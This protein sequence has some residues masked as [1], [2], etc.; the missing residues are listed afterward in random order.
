MNRGAATAAVGTAGFAFRAHYT[1][2]VPMVRELRAVNAP[3]AY[4]GQ[5]A[6]KS[7]AHPAK[8]LLGSQVSLR[9]KSV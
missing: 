1:D 6:Y 8:V 5:F 7:D 3:S 9:V 4:R 2:H